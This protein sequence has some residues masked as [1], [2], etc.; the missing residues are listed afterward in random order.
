VLSVV[1]LIE[2]R[3]HRITIF[4]VFSASKQT[5]FNIS[6]LNTRNSKA[7]E[8]K[9]KLGTVAIQVRLTDIGVPENRGGKLRV[10]RRNLFSVSQRRTQLVH[11]MKIQI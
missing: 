3:N 5:I 8:N 6:I 1:R 11:Y 9:K 4:L 2:F 7:K 10:M